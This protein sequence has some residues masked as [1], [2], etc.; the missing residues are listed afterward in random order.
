MFEYQ[1]EHYENR[2]QMYNYNGMPENGPAEP[3]KP[4]ASPN[5]GHTGKKARI[6]KKAGAITLS[7]ILFGG[8]AA[9]SFQAVN[10]LTGYQT[11]AAESAAAS[12]GNNTASLLQTA[13]LPSTADGKGSLDVSDIAQAVMPSIVSITNKS[14][15]EVQNYFSLFGYGYSGETIPQETESRGSGIIIGKNDTELLIV[16]NYHVIADADILSV[17]F[18]DNQVYEANTKGTDPDNDLAVIAVPLESISADTM[19]QIA[20]ASIGDSD[21]LKVGEQVVAIGNALGYGQSVTTGIV[22]ATNRTLNSNMNTANT[23]E[24]S[25]D[26]PAYIQTDAAIN[27][28][29]SGGALVNMKGEVIGINSAKL[30]STEVEGMGYAIP[31][32]RV[33]DII[34][35]LM[36]ETTRSKVSEDQ[37]SSIG[38]TGITVTESV[39]SVYGIPSGV[40]VAGVT[41]GSGAEKAGLRK[42]DVITKFDGKNITQI[43]ELTELLQYYPAGETVELTIQT[44][45]SDNAYTEKTVSVT[46]GHAVNSGSQS[47]SSGQPE[48]NAQKDM[49]AFY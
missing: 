39:N 18:N 24:D 48:A 27:P 36:N 28:G 44:I 15:Q 40:Y 32:S 13:S 23:S 34:E 8:V 45:G 30:A 35:K 31:V 47:R 6:L 25:A 3:H 17:A 21:S 43:Q 33:S 9:G 20:V 29:N 38:I 19:S 12:A 16:T 42:G 22:S 5:P 26:Q 14:V 4:S 11:P 49:S 2:N 46:L 10:Y 41:E 1:N 37:K 7:A